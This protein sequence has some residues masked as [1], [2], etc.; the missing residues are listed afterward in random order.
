MTYEGKTLKLTTDIDLSSICGEEIGS[1]EPIGKAKKLFRGTFDGLYHTISNI[2][3]NTN[4]YRLCGLFYQNNGTIQ[5]IIIKDAK[6]NSRWIHSGD[7]GL[8]GYAGVIAGQCHGKIKNCAIIGNSTVSF[9]YSN[10]ETVTTTY[11]ILGGIT[12]YA[13]NKTVI[14]NC[15]NEATMEINVK[16]ANDT[17]CVRI[18]GMIGSCLETTITNCYNKGEIIINAP[19]NYVGEGIAGIVG[20]TEFKPITIN[21]SYNIGKITVSGFTTTRKAGIVGYKVNNGSINGINNYYSNNIGLTDSLANAKALPITQMKTSTFTNILNNTQTYSSS[22]DWT[23]EYIQ[24]DSNKWIVNANKND[25]Y[26]TLKWQI[27][28]RY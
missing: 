8:S 10:E 18:G 13:D 1:F 12:G 15:I 2:Y 20:E 9:N 26:P 25:G 14:E 11:L 5:N 17:K 4:M 16:K 6:V 22:I 23:S 3:I 7:E 24:K 19:S 28:K 21:N 27:E